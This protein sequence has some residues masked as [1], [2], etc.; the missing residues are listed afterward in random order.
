MSGDIEQEYFAD[1]VADDIIT[2]LARVR[3]LF[4]I[5]RNSSFAYKG[6][7]VDVRQIASDAETGN[8]VWVDSFDRPEQDLFALQD[9][10]ASTVARAIS[11]AIATAELRRAMRKPPGSLDAWEAYQRGLWHFLTQK[12][13]EIPRARGHFL[14]ALTADPTLSGAY[15]GLAW[16]HIMESGAYGLVPFEDASRLA[17]EQARKAVMADPN[18]PDAHAMLAFALSNLKNW[19]GVADHV[20]QPLAISPSCG[21]AYHVRGMNLVFSGHPSEG[22]SDLLL[23]LQL[24]PHRHGLPLIHVA[25]SYYMQHNYEKAVEV[26]RV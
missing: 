25:I 3:P 5:A 17:A 14:A 21:A 22:R 13:E 8:H 16:L 24:D 23:A 10:I 20:E 6:R 2:E 11:P 18:D 12:L 4:V 9:E 19:K 1:G 7:V 15:T 26:S